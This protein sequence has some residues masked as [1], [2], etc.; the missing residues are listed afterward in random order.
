MRPSEKRTRELAALKK[1]ENAERDKAIVQAYIEHRTIN[2]T[3][4]SFDFMYSREIVRKAI[5]KAG[6][7]DKC[8]RDQALIQRARERQV[9]PSTSIEAVSKTY[10]SELEMQKHISKELNE[11]GIAFEAEVKVAGCGMRADFAGR[12]WA[13]ETK[14][15]CTSQG[16][17]IGMAQCLVYRKHLNKRFVCILLP[18]DI[19]PGS[20]YVSE[21][22][23]YGIPIIKMSQLVWWVNTVQNDAQPN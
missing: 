12:N 14:K 4:K 18:D 8:Q 6:I 17:M 16:I 13:I 10:R 5:S 1:I 3:C 23:S 19:N 7:Y 9:K 20:F 15:E 2:E 11:N 22:L 21:C